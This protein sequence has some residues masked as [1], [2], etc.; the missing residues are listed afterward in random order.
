LKL[1]PK[2]ACPETLLAVK[3]A[4]DAGSV[5]VMVELAS[6]LVVP[7]LAVSV[8]VKVPGVVKV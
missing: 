4:T 2:G 6:V 3:E 1:T 8:T 5:T 7:S